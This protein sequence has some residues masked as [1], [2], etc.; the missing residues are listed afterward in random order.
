MCAERQLICLNALVPP[1]FATKL[2]PSS[3]FSQEVSYL[4]AD[5]FA[6]DRH[7]AFHLA[8]ANGEFP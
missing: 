8:G 5:V 7:D 3:P 2:H 4:T 1:A 6:T